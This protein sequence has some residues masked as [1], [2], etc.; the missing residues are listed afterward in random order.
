M[1]ATHDMS[2][3]YYFIDTRPIKQGAAILDPLF[4]ENYPH[5][6]PLSNAAIP[7]LIEKH[8]KDPVEVAINYFNFVQNLQ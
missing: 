1:S 7:Y 8:K 4:L 6:I 3:L 2:G 5:I